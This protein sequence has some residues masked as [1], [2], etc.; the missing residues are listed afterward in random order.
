MGYSDGPVPMALQWLESALGC[1][2]FVW[3]GDQHDYAKQSVGDATVWLDRMTKELTQLRK[4]KLRLDYVLSFVTGNDSLLADVRTM[5]LAQQLVIGL[6]GREAV[7]AAM[8]TEK[9]IEKLNS[10][11]DAAVRPAA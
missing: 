1:K 9:A 11:G 10:L 8:A 7:D 4:D 6:D 5:T 2:A 3:D